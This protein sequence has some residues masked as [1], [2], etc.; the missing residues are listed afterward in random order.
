MFELAI[1]PPS[2]E[3]SE[4]TNSANKTRRTSE[5]TDVKRKRSKSTTKNESLI[6]KLISNSKNSVTAHPTFLKT[7]LFSDVEAVRWAIHALLKSMFTEAN[8]EKKKIIVKSLWDHFDLSTN[9]GKR[10]VQYTDLLGYFTIKSNLPADQMKELGRK[11]AANLSSQLTQLA[12]HSNAALY[13][14]LS[15][16]LCFG[17]FFLE[18]QPCLACNTQARLINKSN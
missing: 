1:T 13:S 8:P 10:S 15:E 16:Q 5:T 3:K 4:K 7:F 2:P 6:D 12:T 17:G 11:I 9:Y 18:S 14:R